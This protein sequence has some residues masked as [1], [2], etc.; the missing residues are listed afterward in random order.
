MANRRK[1]K[2]PPGLIVDLFELASKEAPKGERSAYS[3]IH[4]DYD[5]WPLTHSGKG[6]TRYNFDVSQDAVIDKRR[7]LLGSKKLRMLGFDPS[8]QNVYFIREIQPALVQVRVKEKYIENGVEKEDFVRDEKGNFV[9]RAAYVYPTLREDKIEWA[10]RKL[11]SEGALIYDASPAGKPISGCS[12]SVYQVKKE[13]ELNG[14]TFDH[15]E[16][17]EGLDVLTGS[18]YTISNE[19]GSGVLFR[20]PRLHDFQRVRRKEYNNKLK[21]KEDTRCKVFFNSLLAKTMENAEI[22]LANYDVQQRLQSVLA[23]YIHLQMNLFFTN[24]RRNGDPM[25]LNLI[26]LFEEACIERGAWNGDARKVREALKALVKAGV[27]K[28]FDPKTDQIRLTNPVDRRATM[29]YEYLLYPSD[30]FVEDTIKGNLHRQEINSRIEDYFLAK[31]NADKNGLKVEERIVIRGLVE[32]GFAEEK[33]KDIP[34]EFGYNYTQEKIELLK[35][36]IANGA[37]IRSAPGYLTALL[38]DDVHPTQLPA[39]SE[40]EGILLE[41]IDLTKY[42]KR[43]QAFLKSN[44]EDLSTPDKKNILKNGFS[45]PYNAE[46]IEAWLAEL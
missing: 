38:R 2:I 26:E 42:S 40:Q 8:E 46:K 32:L 19:D 10:L 22:R 27:L 25:I 7:V 12:F 36:K 4:Y 23:R 13:L 15:D 3:N 39:K 33:A 16:I 1:Q 6:Q 43:Q 24:A 14:S 44:W 45:N 30:N 18:I 41:E 28:R 37:K 20:G 5:V 34:K 35:E 31:R 21:A 17:I 11:A 9:T 29:D